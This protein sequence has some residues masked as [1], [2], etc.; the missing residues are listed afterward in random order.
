M[1]SVAVRG[2][3]SGLSRMFSDTSATSEL[4]E[5]MAGVGVH[6]SSLLVIFHG[7]LELMLKI[8]VRGDVAN[9]LYCGWA[10][11]SSFTGNSAWESI[12]IS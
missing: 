12:F 5:L 7:V 8:I 4:A 2:F 1:V 6:H 11:V 10:S 9:T 3:S